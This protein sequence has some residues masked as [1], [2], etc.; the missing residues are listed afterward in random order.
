MAFQFRHILNKNVFKK[1][2]KKYD[3]SERRRDEN[4]EKAYKKHHGTSK[5]GEIAKALDKDRGKRL[6][7]VQNASNRNDWDVMVHN[8]PRKKGDDD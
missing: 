8:Y 7:K 4:Y 3:K 6:R 2:K 5:M 1:E